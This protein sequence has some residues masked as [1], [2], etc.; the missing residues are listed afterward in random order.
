MNIDLL[1][2]VKKLVTHKGC[3]DGVASALLIRDALP[4]VEVVWLTYGEPAYEG[5]RPEPGMLFCDIVPYAERDTAGQLTA[6]GL[7]QIEAW[8]ASGAL[9]LDHHRGVAD[10]VGMFGERG[11][12]VDEEEE[13][14]VSGAVLAYEE[15]WSELI[16][17]NSTLAWADDAGV[18]RS[19]GV[20][21]P[22]T[23]DAF[24][25]F[26]ELCGIRDTWQKRDTRWREACAQAVVLAFWPA[27][28]LLTRGMEFAFAQCR[29][30]LGEILLQRQEVEDTQTIAEAHRFNMPFLRSPHDAGLWDVDLQV[31][32]FE[33]QSRAASDVAGR[34]GD[35]I[36]PA[37]EALLVIA[38]HY[39][40]GADGVPRV[41]LSCRSKGLFQAVAF[42]QAYGGGGHDHAAGCVLR[43]DRA[44]RHDIGRHTPYRFI[45][46]LVGAAL[47]P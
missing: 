5:L 39:F 29:G 31:V 44:P 41:K 47:S 6:K 9:V 30:P 1:K 28:D 32:V 7:A 21:P 22:G 24:F 25:E 33:G 23:H 27:E 17:D 35:T 14:G 38:W 46:A 20:R 10:L 4:D 3:P 43:E 15:V 26:A 37:R 16:R 2:S 18:L 13:L 8:V 42:A 11:R 12:Y 40:V 45:K 34:L 36:D 19:N